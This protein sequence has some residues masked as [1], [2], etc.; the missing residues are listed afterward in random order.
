MHML[1]LLLAQTDAAG[2]ATQSL[3]DRLG[4]DQLFVVMLVAIGCGTGIVIALVAIIGGIWNSVRQR[5]IEAEM[6]QDMLDRGMT[7]E[8]IEKVVKAQPK[9]GLD[10]WMEVWAK[11]KG[12]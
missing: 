11:K 2:P 12:R 3:L 6:K 4:D 8:E 5:Q 10:H 9:E 7:A 1:P